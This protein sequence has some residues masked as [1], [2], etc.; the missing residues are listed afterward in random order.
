M[1]WNSLFGW[2]ARNTYNRR[3]VCEEALEAQILSTGAH[4]LDYKDF[5]KL[6]PFF[7]LIYRWIMFV[8]S[9]SITDSKAYWLLA[10]CFVC[11]DLHTPRSLCRS[12]WFQNLISRNSASELSSL[13]KRNYTGSSATFLSYDTNRIENDSSNNSS[14]LACILCCGNMYTKP[15][16][17]NDMKD[18]HTDTDW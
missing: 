8:S 3:S 17:S 9:L 14:I 4:D 7:F 6:S 10:C 11:S 18:K 5:F 13:P 12:T 2:H 16:P 1:P 15:L